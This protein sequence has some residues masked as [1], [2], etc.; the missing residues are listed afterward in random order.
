MVDKNKTKDFLLATVAML[1][2]FTSSAF[3]QIRPSRDTAYVPFNVNVNATATAQL[4]GG[5]KFEKPVRASYTDTLLIVTEGNTP[6]AR[7]GK[8]PSPVTMHNSRGKISLEL[9]RQLYRSTDI[10]L[11]SL[12]GKQILHGKA[13]ASEAV[14]S[15]SHPNV[16]MGVYLLSVKGVNGGTFTTRFAH[17][18]GGLNINVAFANGNSA[19]LMKPISGNWTITV[20]ADGYLDT[21]YAFIPETGR[22]NTPVQNIILR[23]TLSPSSS[24][25]TSSSSGA[26]PI[27]L[28]CATVPSSGHVTQPI[29]PPAL[30]C[31][32]GATATGISWLGSPAINWS[33]PAAGAY[34]S[35]SAMATCGTATNLT[36]SCPGTLTVQPTI[37][38]SMASTGYEGTAVTQPVLACSNG[39]A[40]SDIVF[41][42]ILPN[43][44]NP[45]AGTYA[46]FAEA[47]CGLGA[48]PAVSC[49][50]LTVNG[51]TLTCG[52]LPASGHESAEINPPALT[53]S[54]G[55][56]G[57]PAWANAPDWSDPAPG[58][59]SNISAIAT[60]GLAAKTAN[61][62]SLTINPAV[63][64]CAAVPSSGY[65]TKPIIPP[66]LTCSNGKTA[67][68]ISWPAGSP[69][70]DWS[71]PKEGTYNNISATAD[72]GTASGLTANC[73]GTLT[74]EPI[75]SCSMASIGYDGTAITRPVVSCPYGSVP[76]AVAF[77]GTLPDWD[78][79]AIGNY[80]VF[81]E[82]DC[83]FGVSPAVSCG[84]L[85]VNEVVL[86]CGNVP[87]S[88]I[89]D[90]AITPPALTCN[91]GKTPA[92]TEWSASAPNWSNPAHGAYS[93]ISATADCGTS[94]GL[95]AD[96]NGL[97]TVTAVLTCGNVPANGISELAITPPA[98][99]CNNGKTPANTEWSASAPDWSNP[100]H[101]TYSNISVTAD[102]GT[103]V[104]LAANC[105]GT[106]AVT[107]T[108]TC[109]SVP[110]NPVISGTAITPPTLACNN[111]KA[112]TNII[113]PASAPNWSNPVGGRYSNISATATCGTSSSLTANCNGSLQ[114][115]KTVKIGEQ[116]WMAE[117][118]N[119]NATGSLCY[120]DN[121]GGDS[122][123]NCA[124]Y[125]RLYNWATA[126][127]LVSSCNSSSCSSQIQSKHRGICPAGWHIPSRAEWD[128]L[129][130][131][132][133]N[134]SGCSNCS[135]GLLK[136]TSGW[137]NF[138]GTNQYGFSALPGGSYSPATGRFNNIDGGHW[139]SASENATNTTYIKYFSS[140]SN[141]DGLWL[142]SNRSN[143]YYVRC[144]KD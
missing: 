96:C 23:Q 109:G 25:A 128:A 62:S 85:T 38:C 13:V 58:T 57:T 47:D 78:N 54:H 71:N 36:A 27:T 88:G 5:G 133:E 102:C 56:P 46:V 86:T 118:L 32:N 60:C 91:N 121:T 87:A 137:N 17:S 55:T 12:N 129:S 29:T 30:T 73:S 37:S 8:T 111:G 93:D 40:P 125:G 81:V 83:G 11:Y 59:Y 20:S 67:T 105:G 1:F 124:I 18:G 28:T 9:S 122:Q 135:S 82:A 123:G 139:W 112:A 19:S 79:P 41:S 116:T 53:C 63:L 39:S 51:V 127:N 114:V 106:L 80:E 72:C 4:A 100:A 43:W 74:V 45:V 98:L 115:Y 68:G 2:I 69:A 15:M 138:N 143:L 26:V 31:S 44:D 107:A 140:I 14:K 103:S 10:A 35:I 144:L 108:L 136:A 113:W 61:C 89:S 21:S 7:Q 34:S 52:S 142:S 65:A 97:L 75:I 120:G 141:T 110:A 3:A 64:T 119:Y 76:S 49:G 33:N 132:V 130:S 101:G 70:I 92:N 24:S 99:T 134:N 94:V 16:A 131:Y 22:G 66:A 50:T 6:L 90:V 104:G 95:T 117:N 84:T 42:G 48:L 126:M 77:S